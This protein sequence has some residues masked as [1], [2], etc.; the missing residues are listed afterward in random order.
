MTGEPSAAAI[1]EAF[2]SRRSARAAT[3]W[4]NTPSRKN[5]SVP[6][7]TN[8]TSVGLA[9]LEGRP[10]GSMTMMLARLNAASASPSC[11]RPLMSSS[12]VSASA[13]VLRSRSSSVRT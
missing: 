5:S 12:S 9:G 13:R 1:S 2:R 6:P 10:A 7:A 4:A 11:S 8:C 3:M